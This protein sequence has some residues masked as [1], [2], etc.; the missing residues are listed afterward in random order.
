MIIHSTSIS[1]AA[2]I[3]PTGASA[4]RVPIVP[5]DR[6][7]AEIVKISE[8][9]RAALA[10][11]TNTTNES[12]E[13]RLAEIQAKSEFEKTEEDMRYTLAYDARYLEICTKE[14]R[15]P[16]SL[17]ASEIDYMQKTVG[18]VNTMAALNDAE[19]QLYDELVASG[20]TAA[21][22][23]LAQIAAIRYGGHVAAGE[24]NTTYDPNSISITAE[25]I[26]KY[27]RHSVL[28]TSGK[29]DADFLALVE[30]LENRS[31]QLTGD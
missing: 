18:L 8:E 27:F 21:A 20:D 29:A 24:G 10:A 1:S 2:G 31:A 3:R 7:S 17:T 28:D 12:I 9:A 16:G 4:G 23:G 13:A 5:S 25:N 30:Y 19:K 22:S 15:K 26:L 11:Y 14:N 6:I